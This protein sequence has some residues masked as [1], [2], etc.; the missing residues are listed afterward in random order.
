MSE[1]TCDHPFLE[2]DFPF[3]YLRPANKY[4]LLD[5]AGIT[6]ELERYVPEDK[7]TGSVGS[8]VS[9]IRFQPSPSETFVSFAPILSSPRAC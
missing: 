1:F 5:E 9:S 7:P 6:W 8:T 3:S 2:K 4:T